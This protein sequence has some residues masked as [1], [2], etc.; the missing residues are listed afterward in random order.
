VRVVVTGAR[1]FL[2][3][4]VADLLEEGGHDVIRVSRPDGASR[5]L[6]GDAILLDAGDPA[7][8]GLLAGASVV[9]HFA[10][11]PDPARSRSDPA[12]AVRQNAGTT[13]NL[14][15]GCREY[16][17]GLVFPSTVRAALDPPPDPYALSKRL[18]EETCRLHPAP[19]A[20]IRL[21]SVFGPGQ[22]AREGATG[23]IAAFAARALA[24]EPIV[25]AGDPERVRDFVYVDD[26]LPALEEIVADARWNETLTLASGVGTP[27]RRAAE[28]VRDAAG[29][30]SSIETPGGAL[31]AGENLSYGADGAA[32]SLGFGV[33]PLEE[34]IPLYVD[35][36]RRHPTAQSRS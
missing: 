2:G 15:E 19:A 22:V 23:A 32:P 17:C 25:I 18:G 27:L 7:A 35:W 21:T 34:A 6:A 20:V 8:R 33:R 9:L 30:D 29:S 3:S 14:L 10:G 1:G 36:L 28:L 5:A 26:L 16:G 12:W 31:E 4:R 11:V 13:L 24:G